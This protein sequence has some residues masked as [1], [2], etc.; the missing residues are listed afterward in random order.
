MFGNSWGR[1]A[2]LERRKTK[3]LNPVITLAFC[4]KLDSSAGSKQGKAVLLG[5]G[6]RNQSRRD[7]EAGV[8]KIVYHRRWSYGGAWLVES[9]YAALDLR[10]VTS[11]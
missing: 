6:D 11:D 3:K 8:C 5:Q 10:V 4:L 9:E 1:T 7:G 2:I